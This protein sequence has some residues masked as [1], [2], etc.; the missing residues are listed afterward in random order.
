MHQVGYSNLLNPVESASVL[1]CQEKADMT[2]M[3]KKRMIEVW[4]QTWISGNTVYKEEN[5][6]IP[7]PRAGVAGQNGN[8]NLVSFVIKADTV[9][10]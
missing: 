1:F 8:L 7:Q 2:C 10:Y 3:K 9:L 4:A 5:A 6:P